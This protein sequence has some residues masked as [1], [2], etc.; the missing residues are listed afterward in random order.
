[1]QSG[2]SLRTFQGRSLVRLRCWTSTLWKPRFRSI[3]KAR[4]QRARVS[5]QFVLFLDD[6]RTGTQIET[7]VS[8][9]TCSLR[10][11]LWE[12]DFE[13]YELVRLL[14]APT[15]MDLPHLFGG[16]ARAVQ[17]PG[18]AAAY[19]A[20]ADEVIAFH[21]IVRNEH[22]ALLLAGGDAEKLSGFD[23]GNG[24]VGGYARRLLFPLLAALPGVGLVGWVGA[25]CA[26]LKMLLSDDRN[27]HADYTATTAAGAS[28]RAVKR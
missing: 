25:Q 4:C 24:G 22:L 26:S 28:G 19:H 13:R 1:M 20:G 8:L 2:T 15:R 3:A 10:T 18:P 11:Q 21:H 12:T 23:N 6:R 5:D 17:T 14:E 7:K 16:S 27:A 9:S